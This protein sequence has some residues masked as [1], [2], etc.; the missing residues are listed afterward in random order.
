MCGIAGYSGDFDTALLERMN[1]AIAHRGPDDAGVASYPEHR[2]GLAHRRLSI[3]DLSPRGHQPMTDITGTVSIVYN[4]EIY[5]YRALREEL[6]ADG[7]R[8]KSSCDTEVL[9]NLYLR[10]GEKMMERLNGIFAFA[11]YDSRDGSILVVRDGVGVKPLYF[12]QTPK[13]VIF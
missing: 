13:G 12:T 10:D 4:G 1:E 5:N 7:Y 11:L 6:V 2:V 9:L 3:I 8:F